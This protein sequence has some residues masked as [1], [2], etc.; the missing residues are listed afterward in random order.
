M[1]LAILF[2]VL[3]VGFELWNTKEGNK[4]R[5]KVIKLEKEYNE[6]LDKRSQGIRYSQLKLDRIMRDVR[7][8]AENFVKY[9][10]GKQ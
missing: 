5:D 3:K 6:E 2:G 9:A 8:L 10:P 1:D 7:S 4:Y